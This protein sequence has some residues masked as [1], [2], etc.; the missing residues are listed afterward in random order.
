MLSRIRFAIRSCGSGRRAIVNRVG[1]RRKRGGEK[2]GFLEGSKRAT[3]LNFVEEAGRCYGVVLGKGER[4][5]T[6]VERRSSPR[7]RAADVIFFLL[8][9]S[10]SS[11][12]SSIIAI[13]FIPLPIFASP[14]RFRVS[15]IEWNRTLCLTEEKNPWSL[16]KL[17]LNRTPRVRVSSCVVS[18]RT[19]EG[20]NIKGEQ[21][22][23]SEEKARGAC[24]HGEFRVSMESLEPC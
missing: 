22:R 6:R 1:W 17:P 5:R 9:L 16:V 19:V 3:R 10:L 4:R 18:I 11:F 13:S 24:C 21:E 20:V 7:S 12:I 15:R 2:R 8:F 14:P 23:K